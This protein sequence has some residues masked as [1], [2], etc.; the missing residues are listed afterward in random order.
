[1]LAKL[2]HRGILVVY[3][4]IVLVPLTI[5]IFGSFKSTSELFNDPF[6]L[7]SSFAPTNYQEVL[8]GGDLGNAFL[9]STIVALISVPATLFI[10]SLAAYALSRIPGFL[11]ALVFGFLVLGMAIPAQTN[12]IALYV[13]FGQLGL[14]NSLAGLILANI[15]GTMPIAVFILTGFMKTIPQQLFE[16]S[17]IDGT[18]PWRT[19]RSIVMP[20]SAPSLAAA[21]IFLAVIH[22]NELLYPLL[23]IQSPNMRTLPLAL[24]SFQGEYQTNYPALFASV[25]LASAPIVIA[26]VFLQRYFVAGITAGATKG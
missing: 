3:A 9:N 7:P 25:M 21:G 1:M 22:W 23:F 8:T 5:V 4:I 19:Y 14:L 6:T 16:A 26:Y 11:S 2:G 18:G 10:A 24:L 12:M 15:V 13:L 17:S 20:L